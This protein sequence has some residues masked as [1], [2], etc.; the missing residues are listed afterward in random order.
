M[1]RTLIV[2]AASLT[3]CSSGG[4]NSTT[5][6]GT[7]GGCQ[8]SQTPCDGACCSSGQICFTH[9]GGGRSCEVSCS[10]S[11]GCSAPSSCCAPLA[12]GDGGAC[13]PPSE[14]TVA[15][16]C[17]AAHACGS[18]C[19]T[20]SDT[21][22][23][24][25]CCPQSQVCGNT[26]CG[27]G[28]VCVGSVC[29]TACIGPGECPPSSPCCEAAID[30]DGGLEA[31]G[32]CAANPS[33]PTAYACLC[34]T[35]SDCAGLAAVGYNGCAPA[36]DGSGTITGPYVCVD[37]T[38]FPGQGCYLR[39]SEMTCNSPTYCATDNR[40]NQFCA[41]SCS[42]NDGCGNPG[43]ACCNTTCPTGTCCGLCGN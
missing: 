6:T 23:Q 21:C 14:A 39:G 42:S 18:Q 32:F 43:V 3:A 8:A 28:K 16:L 12:S 19:C 22:H 33:S 13:I 40:G 35:Q 4:D 34:S 10:D 9:D 24:G 2:V 7:T 29:Q 26:C 25:S 11:N 38:G 41:I 27:A 36:V 1:W 5:G 20:G 37:Q 30:S 15:C 31:Q 17:D